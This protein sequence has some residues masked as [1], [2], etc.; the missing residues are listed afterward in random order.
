M[1]EGFIDVEEG[2]PSAPFVRELVSLHEQ[3]GINVVVSAIGASER[4]R[5]GGYVV[6]H[7]MPGRLPCRKI[8]QCERLGNIRCFS[9]FMNIHS[10]SGNLGFS[11]IG[12]CRKTSHFTCELSWQ[13]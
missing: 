12:N 13:L 9:K 6:L 4:Q 11:A 10:F 5:A 2:R 8:L 1:S 3:N 7:P